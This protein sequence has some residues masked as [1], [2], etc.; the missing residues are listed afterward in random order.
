MLT[1]AQLGKHY[2][3]RTAL[4]PTSLTFEPGRFCVLLGH[5]GAGKSTLLRCLNQLTE[6]SSGSV[7]VQGLGLV[8]SAA[9]R[10]ALRCMTGF[11]FQQHQLIGRQTA[12]ANVLNGRLGCTPLW[13]SLLP[14]SKAEVELGLA[15]LERVGL[16]DFALTRADRLSGGQQQRVGIARALAQRPRILLADEPVAS[17][18]PAKAGEVL[19]LLQRFCREDGMVTIVSLHQVRLARQYA[20][21]I[22][23]L[24]DGAVVFDAPPDQLSPDAIEAI[25]RVVPHM[26]TQP[27]GLPGGQIPEC[28]QAA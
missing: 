26:P 1:V 6:P 9:K 21:R 2:P 14:W 23:A 25:Y 17:L 16:R 7:E 10:R 27:V 3:A 13:R 5:S 18:D 12:L 4:H 15:C 11:V 19:E 24:R 28:V 8:D 22:I 20:D